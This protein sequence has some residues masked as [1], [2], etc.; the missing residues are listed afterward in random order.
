MRVKTSEMTGPALEWAVAKCQGEKYGAPTFRVH[1]NSKGATVYLNAGMQ[2]SGIPYRPS[3]DWS[4]GGPILHRER[5]TTHDFDGIW[6]AVIFERNSF[7]VP[8]KREP[9]VKSV[10]GQFVVKHIAWGLDPLEAG[11]RCYVASKLGDGVDVPEE[12]LP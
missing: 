12:L 3:T 9:P 11:M 10:F 2:Q 1:Q 8:V 7:G 4:Q 6:L 5:I